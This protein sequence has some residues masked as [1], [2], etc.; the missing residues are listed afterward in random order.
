MFGQV[1]AAHDDARRRKGRGSGPGYPLDENI[2]TATYPVGNTQW[3]QPP[4]VRDSYSVD[5]TVL[6]GRT[7][8]GYSDYGRRRTEP[9]GITSE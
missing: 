6:S 4:T 1:I 5:N 8:L 7:E 9:M 2:L 3:A